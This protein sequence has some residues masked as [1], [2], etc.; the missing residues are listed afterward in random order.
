[1]L[2]VLAISRKGPLTVLLYAQGVSASALLTSGARSLCWDCPVHRR[3]FSISGLYPQE[4]SSI[5]PVFQHDN[6]VPRPCQMSLGAKPRLFEK[7]MNLV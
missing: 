6:N 7:M 5:S 1:M 4:A 3:V 2:A